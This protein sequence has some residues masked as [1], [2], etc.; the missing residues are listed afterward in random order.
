MV[1]FRIQEN[2]FVNC[3]NDQTLR[4]EEFFRLCGAADQVSIIRDGDGFRLRGTFSMGNRRNS[5]LITR[6]FKIDEQDAEVVLIGESLLHGRGGW[7]E[8]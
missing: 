1:N 6:L 5:T 8:K 2:Q 3:D 4:F 7:K